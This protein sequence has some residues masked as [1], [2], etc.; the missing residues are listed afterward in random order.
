[1]RIGSWSSYAI[2]HGDR[3][4]KRSMLRW[5]STNARPFSEMPVSWST[6]FGGV[7][8]QNDTP[9]PHD[10][11]PRG[12]GYIIDTD[13]IDGTPLPNIEDPEDLLE[14]PGQ[15]VRPFG[16]APLP[17][18]SALRI[19]SALDDSTIAGVNLAIYNVAPP[20]HRVSELRGGE[21]CELQGWVGATSEVFELPVES[22]VVEL[23]I[24]NRSYEVWPR[25][26]TVCVFTTQRQLVLTQR[27][28]FVYRYARGAARVARV[29]HT[30]KLAATLKE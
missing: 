21:R 28:T 12:K 11:N 10:A 20:Q 15:R 19:E 8:R 5:G 3:S 18:S 25:L 23:A 2:V 13:G 29:R 16:F 7:A 22:F 9:I 24:E 30:G 6:A 26:D 17:C 4:W 1:M 14:Y 27:A